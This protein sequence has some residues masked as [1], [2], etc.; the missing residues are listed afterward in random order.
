MSMVKVCRAATITEPLRC[1]AMHETATALRTHTCG[2]LRSDHV[3]E[4]VTLAG[5]LHNRRDL[6]GVAFVD[7][8]DHYGITQIVSR[9]GL[10]PDLAHLPK[11]TVI[12]IAG[13]VV[14]RTPET[15]NDQLDTG[16]IEVAAE[17]V[18]ILGPAAP[19]PFN[20]FPEEVSPEESRL[21]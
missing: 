21:R 16:T 20:V 19:L 17:Q 18:E 8:R 7:L 11:E 12:Q 2:E 3:G 10:E 14:A 5:W 9:P 6:G 13:E 15:V 4:R 1:R